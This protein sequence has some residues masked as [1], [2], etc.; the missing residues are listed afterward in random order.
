MTDKYGVIGNPINHSKSPKIHTLFAQQTGQDISYEAIFSEVEA[1]TTTI[2]AFQTSGGKG[3]NVTVPFKE[4]AWNLADNL[5]DRAQLAGAVNTLIFN[6]DGSITGDNTD[7][8][9]LVADITQNLKTELANKKVLVLGAGGAVRGVL[10]PIIKEAPNEITIANRTVAKAIDLAA[11]FASKTDIHAC[12]YDQLDGKQ[13]DV[14]INGTSA[15]LNGEVP[16]IP[17]SVISTNCCCYDMVYSDEPT[18]FV[19]WALDGG[20]AIASDGLGMLVGQAAESFCIWRDVMPDTKAI[21][22]S[23]RP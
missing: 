19:K 8:A 3:M 20:A 14:I 17:A 12:G 1:F 10:L 11:T 22:K 23:I 7:G 4:E 6:N 15:G 5:S 16:P 21:M 18:A 2:R 9:G 13:F